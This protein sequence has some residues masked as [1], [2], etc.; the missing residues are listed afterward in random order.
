MEE[1]V[2]LFVCVFLVK[3]RK[4]LIELVKVWLYEIK[5]VKGIESSHFSSLDVKGVFGLVVS[6]ICP[7]TSLPFNIRETS[8][9]SSSQLFSFVS[10]ILSS[11][12]L[13]QC[14]FGIQSEIF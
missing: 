4:D 12:F 11:K 9:A 8:L 14:I 6:Y 1:S 5:L 2:K 13:H 7:S 3:L 10:L